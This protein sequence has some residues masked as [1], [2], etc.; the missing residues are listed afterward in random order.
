M[1]PNEA[2]MEAFGL[3][4]ALFVVG[5]AASLYGSLVGLG[6]GFIAL[7]VLRLFFG[8]PTTEVAGAS[9]VMVTVSSLASGSA[10]LRARRIDVPLA[11]SFAIFGIPGS[12]IGAAL[13][14]RIPTKGFDL[15]YAAMLFVFATQLI[16]GKGV[17]A[18]GSPRFAPF[19]TERKFTD[20][21]GKTWRYR[22]SYPVAAVTGFVVGIIS[23]LF[24]IGGGVVQVPAMIGL[25]GI[26]AHI[27]T[28]TSAG[29]I[30]IVGLS[31]TF[32]HMAHGD[33]HPVYAVP[34]ALGALVGGQVGPLINRRISS[35]ALLKALAAALLLAAVGLAAKHIA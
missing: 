29:I 10:F 35:P 18:D 19:S 17:K 26:P 28:A 31:G 4:L 32:A 12:I 1:Q 23:S 3:S 11:L 8:L 25:F 27:A 14:H 30:A 15:A 34:L 5:L 2:A 16:L 24:G 7:P 13:S 20:R 22:V 33:V 6:G 9:I 21:D